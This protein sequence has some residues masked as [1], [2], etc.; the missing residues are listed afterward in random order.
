MKAKRHAL[1]ERREIVG[2]SQETLARA[3]GMELTT[4]GR[5]ERGETS[6][7]PPSRPKLADALEISLEELDRMLAEGQPI[8]IVVAA[9][10]ADEPAD[11]PEHDLVLTAPWSHGATGVPSKRQSC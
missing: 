10:T 4:I 6:P 1:A 2:H 11:D 9:D 8:E 7:Q 3:L 5:W